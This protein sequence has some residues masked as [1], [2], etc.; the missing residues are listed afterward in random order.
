MF[1]IKFLS[2]VDQFVDILGAFERLFTTVHRQPF[3]VFGLNQH[4]TD[5]GFH[6]LRRSLPKIVD[7]RRKLL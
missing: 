6:F 3:S 4:I 2:R 1:R 5:N 7:H